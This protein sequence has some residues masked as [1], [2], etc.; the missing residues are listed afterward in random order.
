MKQLQNIIARYFEKLG[1]SHDVGTRCSRSR[2]VE[3]D[4][5]IAPS[6]TIIT[7][8][9]ADSCLRTIVP[10]VAVDVIPNELEK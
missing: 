6:S 9:A 5:H 7:W 2:I 10:N 3:V 1:S 8:I 4:T